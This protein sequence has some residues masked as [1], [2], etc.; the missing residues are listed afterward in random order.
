MLF[1]SW[2]G[3]LD[4]FDSDFEKKLWICSS[5]DE[6][7]NDCLSYGWLAG[8]FPSITGLSTRGITLELLEYNST[9]N[10]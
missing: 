10:I 7:Q 4:V 1:L 6:N 9:E 5:L 3:K 2:F 8:G